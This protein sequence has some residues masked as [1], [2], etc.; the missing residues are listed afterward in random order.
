MVDFKRLSKN[1]SKIRPEIKELCK[2]KQLISLEE[3][4]GLHGN[5]W[6]WDAIHRHLSLEATI[7]AAEHCLKNCAP[8]P[9]DPCTVYEDAMI[10]IHVPK[11]LRFLKILDNHAKTMDTGEKK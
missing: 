3:Y 9:Q 2:R 6:E 4:K 7:H 1:A 11:M 10:N 8:R 5:S